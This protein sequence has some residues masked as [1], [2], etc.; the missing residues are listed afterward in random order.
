METT[1]R[2]SRARSLSRDP[3]HFTAEYVGTACWIVPTNLVLIALH[4]THKGSACSTAC[5][6]MLLVSAEAEMRT[7]L[8]SIELEIRTC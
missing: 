3:F 2:P 4:R 6:V 7:G 8:R 1:G 5:R